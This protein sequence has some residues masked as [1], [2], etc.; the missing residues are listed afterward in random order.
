MSQPLFLSVTVSLSCITL[1]SHLSIYLSIY[2]LKPIRNI[3]ARAHAHIY[4]YVCIHARTRRTRTQG[5]Q[6][7]YWLS[8]PFPCFSYSVNSNSEHIHRS[9][10]CIDVPGRARA[11][12]AGEGLVSF[13]IRIFLSFYYYIFPFFQLCIVLF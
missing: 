10:L 9:Q 6:Q 13:R 2:L 5:I 7:S 4:I 8:P 3:H 1:I 11:G 12:N